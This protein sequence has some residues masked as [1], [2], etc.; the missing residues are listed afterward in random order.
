MNCR[1]CHLVDE[2]L[3]TPGGGVRTYADFAGRSPIPDRGDGHETTLRNSPSLVNS[4]LPRPSKRFFLH[5]DGEFRS[6]RD[7]VTATLT[8]RNYG[9]LPGEQDLAIAHVASVLRGDDGTG[10]LAQEFGG[11]YAA[12]LSG[13]DPSL[14]PELVLPG[15]FRINA[16]KASDKQLVKAAAR[17]I[18]AYVDQLRFSQDGD[19]HYN[20]SPYDL[21]L[22]A[23]ALPS[24]PEKNETPQEYAAHLAAALDALQ[25]PD[26]I[27]ASDGAFDFHDQAFVFGAEELEGLKVFL[28]GPPQAPGATSG[29]GNCAACHLLPDM[30]DFAFHNTGATQREYDDL[31]GSGAFE[32]L[33]VPAWAER[34]ADFDAFLPPTAKHPAALG[35][36]ASVP[37]ADDPSKVDLGLWNVLFNP[38]VPKPQHGL[39]QLIGKSFGKGSKTEQL[40]KAI[41]LFKTPSLRDLGQ[42]GPYLHNALF[43]TLPDVVGFYSEV[44]V[45]A[46]AGQLRN[47]DPRLAEIFLDGADEQALAAFLAALAEDYS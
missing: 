41:A 7:L 28:R 39:R 42:S 11:S 30:T 2:H 43:G 25:A 31:H 3:D 33:P 26:Y 27:D 6:T 29:V 21:F 24:A 5:L 8:G 32:L 34:K 16:A 13:K 10:T 23:N 22:A 12:V 37:V 44:S 1:A 38:D 15:K 4:A 14:P 47:A 36:F 45:L 18:S 40:G 19:G 20:A 9:W 35:P 46:R 17:L